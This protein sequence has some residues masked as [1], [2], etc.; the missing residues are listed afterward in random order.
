[1]VY[2]DQEKSTVLENLKS[3]LAPIL[4]EPYIWEVDEIVDDIK[5]DASWRGLLL[6][7]A[8]SHEEQLFCLT[9]NIHGQ[10]KQILVSVD[11]D[12]LF[13]DFVRDIPFS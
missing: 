13:L 1:M 9:K 4:P 3:R 2:T 12:A 10:I 7:L 11:E 6:Q 5:I 8:Y